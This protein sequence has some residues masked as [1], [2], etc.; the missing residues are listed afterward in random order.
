[1][2]K[3]YI[4]GITGAS[5][6]ILSLKL[7]QWFLNKG[8]NVDVLVSSS[9]Y[10][11]LFFEVSPLLLDKEGLT[12]FFENYS[13]KQLRLFDISDVS[14]PACSGSYRHQGMI[15][16]PC[17]MATVSAISIGFANNSIRRAADVTIKENRTLIIVPR[18]TPFSIIHLENLL[19]LAKLGVVI[20]PPSP[21][22]YLKLKSLEELENAIIGKVL[23]MLEEEHNLYVPW[24]E[25]SSS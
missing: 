12:K 16:I 20:L 2:N 13:E 1:M 25:E 4:V 11:A 24:S 15:I 22:W 10:K 23:D 14:C 8:Y 21:Q 17:S 3:T 7:I 9:G 18:E 5:G 19:R 6:S